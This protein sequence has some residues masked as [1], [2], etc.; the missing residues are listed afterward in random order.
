RAAEAGWQIVQTD[1]P[2][3]PRA[4]RSKVTGTIRGTVQAIRDMSAVLA[5]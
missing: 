4:G 5:G 2:Y 1:V 3:T